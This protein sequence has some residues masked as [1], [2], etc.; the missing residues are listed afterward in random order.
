[1]SCDL[2]SRASHSCWCCDEQLEQSD[3][4][5]QLVMQHVGCYQAVEWLLWHL[6]LI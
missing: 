5:D 4:I 3:L 1:L 2:E 6:N